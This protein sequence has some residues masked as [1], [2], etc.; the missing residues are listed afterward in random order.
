VA[1]AWQFTLIPAAA[2][3]IGAVIA[4]NARPKATLVSAIQH[5]AA[6]VVFAA[7][8]GEILPD[9]MHRGSPWATAIG[10]AIG[11]VTM[12]LVKQLEE[13]A[14]GPAGLLTAIAVD[15][16]IDGLVLGIGFAASPK[17]GILL[18]IALTIEILFLGLTVATELG[19]SVRSK[20]RIV[21]ITAGLIILLPVGAL[22]GAPVALL[23][24]PILTGFFAFGLVALLYL[25]TEELLIEAHETPDRPW[26]TAMFF[27]GFLALLLVEEAIG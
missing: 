13:W 7:A 10:G 5:F 18:T 20:A 15:I 17:V 23:P 1:S 8:A 3:M 16:L 26:V 2:A 12:L 21:G 19:E 24:G 9:V 25:V 27:F 14:K 6:G 22:L 11:V 4:V